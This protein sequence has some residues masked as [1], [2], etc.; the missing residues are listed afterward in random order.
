MKIKTI[1]CGKIEAEIHLASEGNWQN[2]KNQFHI[3][4]CDCGLDYG[5]AKTMDEIE[6]TFASK[7]L[8]WLATIPQTDDEWMKKLD[9]CMNWTGYE[10][11]N[12][13]REQALSV[14]RLASKHYNEEVVK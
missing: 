11:C 14:L 8:E 12:L 4:N 2:Y 10:Q 3:K 13:S 5:F 6:E 1:K 7:T 9:D